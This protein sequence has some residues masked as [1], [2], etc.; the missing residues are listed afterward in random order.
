MKVLY[1][2]P[3]EVYI[4][5]RNATWQHPEVS[6]ELARRLRQT[7]NEIKSFEHSVEVRLH[8]RIIELDTPVDE[9]ARE[10]ERTRTRAQEREAENDKRTLLQKV[11]KAEADLRYCQGQLDKA[12]PTSHT[13]PATPKSPLL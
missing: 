11:A 2:Q 9:R 4:S 5:S 8:K 10:K 7:L 6:Q 12:M 13:T 3:I 1:L